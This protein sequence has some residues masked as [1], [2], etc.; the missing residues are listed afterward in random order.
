MELATKKPLDLFHP[1][2]REEY[3]TWWEGKRKALRQDQDPWRHLAMH[4]ATLDPFVPMNWEACSAL[5]IRRS[6]P[7]FNREVL[8]LAYECHP[9]E[10][11]GPGTKKLLRAALHNDVPSRN[12]YRQDKGRRDDAAFKSMLALQEPPPEEPLPEEL[13]QVLNSEWLANPPATLG[14]F[15]YRYL[16]RLLIFVESLRARRKNQWERGRGEGGKEVI[17]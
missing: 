12:L 9:T 14:Y 10:L 11:Y 5:G 17:K 8:E 15:Q 4:S 13:A 16:T 2:V 3:L 7:F 1:A 6:F